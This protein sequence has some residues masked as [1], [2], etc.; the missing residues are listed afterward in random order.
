MKKIS[1]FR[2][3][4]DK[5]ILLLLRDLKTFIKKIL[6]EKEIQKFIGNLSTS[7]MIPKKILH[8]SLNKLF[9]K[10]L[11]IKMGNLVKNFILEI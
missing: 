8:L 10:I 4:R 3:N 9:I 7:L 1:S 2:L 5:N 11:K 6:N